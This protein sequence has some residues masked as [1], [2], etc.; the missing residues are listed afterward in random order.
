MAHILALTLGLR[1]GVR[2]HSAP[3]LSQF[4]NIVV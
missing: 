4:G 1:E 3:E 2:V